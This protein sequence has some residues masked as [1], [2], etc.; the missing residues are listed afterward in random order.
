MDPLFVG[1]IGGLGATVLVLLVSLIMSLAV[2]LQYK[3]KLSDIQTDGFFRPKFNASHH[4]MTF[5]YTLY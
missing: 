3:R 2:T 1:W 4:I 5:R